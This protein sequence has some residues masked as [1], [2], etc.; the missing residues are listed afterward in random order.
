MG[1]SALHWAARGS[2]EWHGL[3][4]VELLLDAGA[5]PQAQTKV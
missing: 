4:M 1:Y 2:M 3:A 5:N